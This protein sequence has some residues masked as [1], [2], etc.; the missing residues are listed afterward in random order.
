MCRCGMLMFVYG[1][2]HFELLRPISFLKRSCRCLVG[3][4]WQHRFLSGCTAHTCRACALILFYILVINYRQDR[5]SGATS[6]NH[7][8]LRAPAACC[9]LQV[10]LRLPINPSASV[11]PEVLVLLAMLLILRA[12]TYVVLRR[13]T[14]ATPPAQ[15]K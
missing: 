3:D 2:I 6:I 5:E 8:V 14:A 1:D 13:K 7:T 11:Y 4:Y 10:A 9:L 15:H 12:A